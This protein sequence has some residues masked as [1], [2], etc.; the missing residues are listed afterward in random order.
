[1][2]AGEEWDFQRYRSVNEVWM[3]KRRVA[4]DIMLLEQPTMSTS[5]PLLPLP[6]R[7]LKE[8][9]RPYACYATLILFGPHVQPCITSLF[10]AYDSLSQMQ[11][12]QPD[13][14]IWS[15]TPL[16]GRGDDGKAT[17]EGGGAVVRVAGKG[18]ELVRNWLKDALRDMAETIGADAYNTAFVG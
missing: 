14:L 10:K 11:L 17:K 18:T 16:D 3:G 8:R 5:T 4:R 6:N 7:P 9:L 15:L 12:S 2:A 1:M 13:D